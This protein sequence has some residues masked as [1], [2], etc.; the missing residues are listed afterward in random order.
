MAFGTGDAAAGAEADIEARSRRLPQPRFV[1]SKVVSYCCCMWVTTWE[2]AI[3]RGQLVV[4]KGSFLFVPRIDHWFRCPDE[5]ELY[6]FMPRNN[7]NQQC[8]DSCRLPDDA[9]WASCYALRFTI[10]E[11]HCTFHFEISCRIGIA[12]KSGPTEAVPIL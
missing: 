4:Y 2:G 11:V 1:G 10:V 12:T 9:R 8:R 6:S 5:V 3:E 7:T